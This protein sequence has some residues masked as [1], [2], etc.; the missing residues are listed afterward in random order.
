LVYAKY[1]SLT[2]DV[3]GTYLRTLFVDAQSLLHLKTF[4]LFMQASLDGQ[5]ATPKVAFALNMIHKPLIT[6][7]DAYETT[8]HIVGSVLFV[9]HVVLHITYDPEAAP[10]SKLDQ[11]KHRTGWTLPCKP[12]HVSSA[13]PRETG[14]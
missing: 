1:G 2:N 5:T 8:H 7:S 4:H 11:A 3:L 13:V 12:T 6:Y 14:T 9:Q 10:H